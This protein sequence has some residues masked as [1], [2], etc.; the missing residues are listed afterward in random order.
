MTGNQK[1]AGS[2]PGNEWLSD[3]RKSLYKYWSVY[4]SLWEVA[5]VTLGDPL[6]V[7]G[8]GGVRRCRSL[9]LQLMTLE[10]S[11]AGS[12]VRSSVVSSREPSPA[13]Q[14]W[15]LTRFTYHSWG[16]E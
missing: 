2:I 9:T 5:A 4:H 14:H 16:E 11:A 7:M 13:R 8:E 10:R 12:L 3:G 15:D 6:G 1:V